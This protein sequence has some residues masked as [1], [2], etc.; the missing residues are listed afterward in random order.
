MQNNSGGPEIGKKGAVATR[1][2]WVQTERKA[3]ESWAR[4]IAEKPR[5]AALMHHLVALMGPQN[6]VVISQKLLGQLMGV[7]DRT[8]RSAVSDLVGARW[9]SMVKLNGPGTVAAYVVNS[10][11]AWGES[12]NNLSLSAFSATVI[13]DRADQQSELLG[14]ALRRIPTLFAGEQQLPT[15]EGLDPPSQPTLD[16]LE[17]DLPARTERRPPRDEVDRAKLEARG[18]LRLDSDPVVPDRP[19]K[20]SRK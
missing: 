7:T 4:L 1:N 15:G 19:H 17:P 6:A 20:R 12:R 5:A 16:G 11:V 2:S 3:H 13:A 14:D 9:I 18:Q 10:Q 8:V